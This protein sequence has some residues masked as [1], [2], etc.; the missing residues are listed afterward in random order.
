MK[1]RGGGNVIRA[2]QLL[3]R[4]RRVKRPT[5]AAVAGAAAIPRPLFSQPPLGL[6]SLRP[7]QLDDEDAD[8]RDDDRQTC[9]HSDEPAIHFEGVLESWGWRGVVRAVVKETREGT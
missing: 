3:V 9:C 2:E 8:E 7:P 1:N 4:W 5:L 6:L